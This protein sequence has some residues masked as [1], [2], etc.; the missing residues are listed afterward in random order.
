MDN[1]ADLN[2]EISDINEAAVSYFLV[3]LRFPVARLSGRPSL[4]H[5]QCPMASMRL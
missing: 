4:R 2:D 5:M 1:M 3:Q